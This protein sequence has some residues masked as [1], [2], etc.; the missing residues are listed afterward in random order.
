LERG[1]SFFTPSREMIFLDSATPLRSA[2]NDANSFVAFV[3]FVVNGFFSAL[4]APPRELFLDC[5]A[6]LAMTPFFFAASRET[7]FP[8]SATPL[9]SAQNDADFFVAFVFF[10]VNGFFSA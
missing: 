6:A 10:V 4:S 2:Q 3:F 8:D 5:F 7:I 9:R 1:L